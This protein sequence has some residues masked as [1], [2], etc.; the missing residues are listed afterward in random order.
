MV[1]P[2]AK[3]TYDPDECT[4]HL[5]P[6]SQN[7]LGTLLFCFPYPGFHGG[8]AEGDNPQPYLVWNFFKVCNDGYGWETEGGPCKSYNYWLQEAAANNG[9]VGF[10]VNDYSSEG[11]TQWIISAPQ[12]TNFTI[13]PNGC[14]GDRTFVVQMWY[15]QDGFTQY[16]P[17]SN[18]FTINCPK[19]VG[20]VVMLDFAFD[21]LTLHNL[22]D[23]DGGT[24]T[25]ELFGYFQVK[26]PSSKLGN[27]NFL[28]M[29][30]WDEQWSDCPDDTDYFT[31]N[32]PGSCTQQ[33][34]NGS[35]NL[36][37]IPL[38]KSSDF[39]ESSEYH[40]YT[41]F[42]NQAVQDSY[43][44][45]NNRLRVDMLDGYGVT[46]A[47]NLIDWDDASGNDSVCWGVNTEMADGKNLFEWHA[48]DGQ[49]F[50]LIGFGEDGM[51]CTINGTIHVIE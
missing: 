6:D 32:P 8:F 18:P 2:A 28:K 29:G 50:A 41:H 44:T 10:Y 40:C 14:N 24:Q 45:N 35:H 5:P 23:G 3:V 42:E 9:Q 38:C 11:H 47:V 20:N 27:N 43:Q 49:S 17:N 31:S 48:M 36:N 1:A 4:S 26:A 34:T 25:V 37:A 21:S 30:A 22:D 16:S 7:L 46:L 33:L 39:T 12:L 15:E 19:A 51:T 13:P